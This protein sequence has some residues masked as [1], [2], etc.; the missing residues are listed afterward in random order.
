MPKPNLLFL[1]TDEQ[2]ADTM[3]A[4]GNERIETPNLNRLASES[5]VFE[6]AYVTQPV[7]TPSRSSILTGLWPHTNGCTENNIPLRRDTLCFPEMLSSGDYV[8]GY[9]GKWHLGDEIFAQHGFEHWRAIEDGYRGY[10]REGRDREAR[11]TYCHWLIEKGLNPASGTAFSRAEATRL[12][13]QYG[14]PAYLA[15]EASQFIRE[16]RNNPFVL[17]V[18]F[19]EPH[20]PF[21][22]PRDDQHPPEEITLPGNFNN[23][24]TEDQPLKTRVLQRGYH[25][26]GHGGEPLKTEAD[27]R[28][29][30]A[31]YWGLCSLVDTHVGTI[32]RTLD[33]CGLDDNTIVVYT[34]DHGDMMGSHRMLAKC[35]MFEEAARVPLL[36]RLPGQSEGRRIS[37]PVS[38]IDLVPSLLELMEQPIP[39]HLQGKSLKP[40]IR[41]DTDA[42]TEDV[43]VEWNGPNSGLGGDPAGKVSAED[44]LRRSPTRAQIEAAVR[45]P[46]RTVLTRDGWKYNHSPLGEHELYNL[47][48]DPLETKNLV[49]DP[50]TQTLVQDLTDRIRR[51]Q[52]NTE[53]PAPI[54]RDVR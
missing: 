21:F 4:Y 29:L 28:K 45:D 23:P 26:R 2:R 52:E 22:G 31:R 12:P 3:A 19:L 27:W 5:T 17:F 43:F 49:R 48:T 35:T 38:Q 16:N 14:K 8:S 13:E 41:G 54:L 50:A 33:E 11:S 47:K 24:P 53:D 20:M 7:C 18:N 51:W 39:S 46:V 30:I 42:V 44:P 37:G 25:E 15:Q 9:H 32:L 34:S 6:R 1:F 40:L 10:Y 36:I